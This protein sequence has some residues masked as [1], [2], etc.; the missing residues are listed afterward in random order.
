MVGSAR[1]R[2]NQA[3]DAPLSAEIQYRDAN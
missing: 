3:P 2:R 1:R